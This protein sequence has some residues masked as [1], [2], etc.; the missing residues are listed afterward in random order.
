MLQIEVLQIEVSTFGIFKK[1]LSGVVFN[2]KQV[3]VRFLISLPWNDKYLG[4]SIIA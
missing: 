3:I 4:E 1:W 2:N